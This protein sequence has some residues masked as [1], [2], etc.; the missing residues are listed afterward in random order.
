V[1]ALLQAFDHAWATGAPYG[2]FGPRQ[3]WIAAVEQLAED[4]WP[5]VGGRP[6]WRLG[7]VT[8]R[9]SAVSVP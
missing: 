2:S 7:E 6:R 3:R 5:V 1:H 4:G 8:F 9:W